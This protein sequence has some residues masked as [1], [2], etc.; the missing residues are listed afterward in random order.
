MQCQCKTKLGLQCKNLAAINSKYCWQHQN[1]KKPVYSPQSFKSLGKDVLRQ[2]LLALPDETL[3]NLCKV[4][5]YISR[6]ICKDESFWKDKV[7]IKYPMFKYKCKGSC[8]TLYK[9][10]VSKKYPAPPM[11]IKNITFDQRNMV[12]SWLLELKHDLNVEPVEVIPNAMLLLDKCL[13]YGDVEPNQL[14]LLGFLCFRIAYNTQTRLNKLLDNGAIRHWLDSPELN[15]RT[16]SQLSNTLVRKIDPTWIAVVPDIRVN[17]QY[18]LT[19]EAIFSS[20]AKRLV[21][22]KEAFGFLQLLLAIPSIYGL[23]IDE[24]SNI[25]KKLTAVYLGT[26]K[27]KEYNGIILDMLTSNNMLEDLVG[28]KREVKSLFGLR[29]IEGLYD[30]LANTLSD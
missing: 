6:N 12:Y 25:C 24:I 19:D 1:C 30:R 23:Y 11:R 27:T 3:V 5:T 29:D 28:L 4:E 9:K 16:I 13:V 18:M 17:D 14:Q 22:S 10:L 2:F 20:P 7:R 8:E 15:D 26:S 21:N